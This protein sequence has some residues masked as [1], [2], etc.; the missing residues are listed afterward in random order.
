MKKLII[1]GFLLLSGC[2]TVNYSSP[3]GRKLEIQSFGV[4][5]TLGSLSWSTP[6]GQIKIENLTSQ[7]Q[8]FQTLQKALDKVPNVPIP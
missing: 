6:E 1:L 8:F 3:E 7:S 2:K 4:D 5:N